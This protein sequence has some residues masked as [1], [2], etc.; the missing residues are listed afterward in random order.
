MQTKGNYSGGIWRFSENMFQKTGDKWYNKGE[1][2]VT[3][4]KKKPSFWQIY[5]PLCRNKKNE[6][7]HRE[8][9]YIGK[10]AKL[11]VHLVANEKTSDNSS[12]PLC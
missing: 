6:T 4:L 2:I 9:R 11:Y 8:T 7:E 5:V 10:T 12:I 1:K 3:F